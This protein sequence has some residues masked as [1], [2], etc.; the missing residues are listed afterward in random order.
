MDFLYGLPHGL[1]P[2]FRDQRKQKENN[3]YLRLRLHI[4][5]FLLVLSATHKVCV[6][7]IDSDMLKGV[8][9]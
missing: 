7:L 1:D 4:H 6:A 5:Q 2:P 3:L 9:I 8:R